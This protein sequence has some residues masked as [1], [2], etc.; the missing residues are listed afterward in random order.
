MSQKGF[1]RCPDQS[2]EE[3]RDGQQRCVGCDDTGWV[4]EECSQPDGFCECED[5]SRSIPC[6]ACA[7]RS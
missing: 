3:W 4:C 5:R 6:D 1:S 2:A 7:G